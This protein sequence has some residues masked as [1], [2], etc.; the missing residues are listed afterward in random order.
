MANIKETVRKF[1]I[2]RWDNATKNQA[3]CAVSICGAVLIATIPSRTSLNTSKHAEPKLEVVAVSTQVQI[4]PEPNEIE[5]EP[6]PQE[7]SSNAVN[8]GDCTITYYCPC[9]KCNGNADQIARD[10]T[11]LVPYFTCAVDPDIIPLGSE[12][13]IDFGGGNIQYFRACDTGSAIKD[14][15]IDICVSTHEEA[16]ELGVTTANVSYQGE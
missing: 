5:T 13:Q 4:I 9:V 2:K 6:I 3:V 1:L 12:V 8:L 14:K 16:L 7:D 15:H 11:K 10:G